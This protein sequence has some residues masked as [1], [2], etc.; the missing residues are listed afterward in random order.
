M[1]SHFT[2]AVVQAPSNPL[3]IVSIA[4]AAAKAVLP[5]EALLLEAGS[6][7]FG[8]DVLVRISSAMGFAERVSAGDERNRLL[9]VHCHA[10]ERLSNVSGCSERIRVTVRPLRIHVDQTHLNGTERI[11]QFPVA[12]V[13]LVSKP[14]G[15]RPPV[16][17]FFG[18]PDVLAPAGETEGL[19]IPS[20][21]RHS[22]R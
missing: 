14:R 12:G 8:T 15:L 19:E 10:T 11:L 5:A 21:P 22:S 9:V 6:L 20:T 17:V 7:G 2:G 13:A 4:L 18:L 3:V 16:D 1:L